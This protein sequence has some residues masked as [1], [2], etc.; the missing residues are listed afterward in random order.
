MVITIAGGVIY[1][2]GAIGLATC[3][4]DPFPRTFGYHEVWHVMTVAAG[5]CFA[6]VVFSLVIAAI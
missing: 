2:V 4:P 6:V 5:V 3:W 1:T